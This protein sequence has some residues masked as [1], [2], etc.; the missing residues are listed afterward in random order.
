[1][2]NDGCSEST[3][4]VEGQFACEF[5]SSRGCCNKPK[6][7]FIMQGPLEQLSL[8]LHSLDAKPI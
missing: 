1:M 2:G 7:P 8:N 4:S 6:D 5:L 3:R